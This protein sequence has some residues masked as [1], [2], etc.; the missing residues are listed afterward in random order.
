M[1]GS[2]RKNRFVFG[3]LA[4]TLIVA[5]IA[6]LGTEVKAAPSEEADGGVFG[7]MSFF[8]PFAL[9]RVFV[10]ESSP[11][12]VTQGLPGGDR[13]PI[14]IPFRPSLRSPFRPPVL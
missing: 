6:V 2:K 13:P 4:A 3:I 11:R 1:N 8:E 12:L 14:R 5:V 10:T 9:T 7:Q